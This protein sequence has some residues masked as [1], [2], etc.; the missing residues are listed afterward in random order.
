MTAAA[1]TVGVTVNGDAHGVAPGTTVS[2]LLAAL[3]IE[4]RGTAVAVDGEVVTRRTWG[5]RVL[6]PGARVEVLSIAQ[7]G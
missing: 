2:G 3:G 5:E 1:G 4:P 6:A 7:G